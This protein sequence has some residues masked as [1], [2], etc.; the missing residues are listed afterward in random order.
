MRYEIRRAAMSDTVEPFTDEGLVDYS[1]FGADSSNT[2]IHAI[3]YVAFETNLDSGERN[4]S[5]WKNPGGNY[6]ERARG[7]VFK[8]K[9][10]PEGLISGCGISGATNEISIRKAMSEDL[11][12]K[13]AKYWHPF[14]NSHE[15]CDERYPCLGNG[16]AQSGDG[17][18][19]QCFAQKKGGVYEVENAMVGDTKKGYAVLTAAEN[20]MKPPKKPK[21]KVKGTFK[22]KK[23]KKKVAAENP[24][25]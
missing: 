23:N 2:D 25:P 15:Q 12:L 4:L 1:A 7:F 14:E 3:N 17:V 22:Q 9:K 8:T 13:P 20:P 24:A 21:A 11:D 16:K 5:Y 19:M 6:S 10:G 18:T